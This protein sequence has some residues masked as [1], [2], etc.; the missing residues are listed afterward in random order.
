MWLPQRHVPSKLRAM[1]SASEQATRK[2]SWAKESADSILV[3]VRGANRDPKPAPVERT[4]RLHE[5]AA[6][7]TSAVRGGGY[8]IPFPA[9]GGMGGSLRFD[10]APGARESCAV[11]MVQ[12]P[13]HFRQSAGLRLKR[14]LRH[15]GAKWP[16]G[17][18]PGDLLDLGLVADHVQFAA[19]VEPEP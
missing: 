4:I 8:E 17:A 14:P 6:G 16:A 13:R 10:G 3:R 12:E 18:G 9:E 5:D 2:Y 1:M 7:A 19:G 15:P 11:E